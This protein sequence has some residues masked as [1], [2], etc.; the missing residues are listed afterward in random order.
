M[1]I[2]TYDALTAIYK[3]T[4]VQHRELSGHETYQD[5][6]LICQH[7]KSLEN[8][9]GKVKPITQIFDA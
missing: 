7:L 4:A 9:I 3:I 6:C 2:S 5:D 8:I 1:D